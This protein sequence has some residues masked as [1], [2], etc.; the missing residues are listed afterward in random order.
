MGSIEQELVSPTEAHTVDCSVPQGSVLSPLSFVAYTG[1]IGDVS[2]V[3]TAY[4]YTNTLTTNSCSPVQGLTAQLTYVDS[5]VIVVV[6]L[7]CGTVCQQT[8]LRVT[9]FLFRREL[10]TFL[11]RQSYPSILL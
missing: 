4:L 6:V 10:K 1:D 11:F 3:S 7:C 9:H 8:L 5:S 2:S